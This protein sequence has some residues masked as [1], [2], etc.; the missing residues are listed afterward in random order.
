MAESRLEFKIIHD[1]ENKNVH[2]DQMSLEVAKAFVV[3]IQSVTSI[4]ELTP[5]NKELKI[6]VKKGSAMICLEGTEVNVVEKKF[7]QI[8][9]NKS[10][11]A[12]LVRQWRNIQELFSNNGLGYEASFYHKNAKVEI[13]DYLKSPKRLRTKRRS[14]PPISTNIEFVIGKLIAVGG[15]RPNIH[16]EINKNEKA[17]IIKC[18]EFKANK[19]KAFLYKTIWI[20]VWVTNKGVDK[21]F[22]MC[23]SYWET[24]NNMF[25]EFK[26]FISSMQRAENEIESLKK[27][28]YKC[29]EILKEGDFGKYRKFLRLF[30]TETSDLNAL[31]TILIVSRPFKDHER[32][33][34]LIEELDQ[35]F[36]KKLGKA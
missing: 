5:K 36:Q 32:L 4:V 10:S 16:V 1:T 8:I 18:T 28:H 19:A 33:Q 24:Q 30:N 13:L 12:E 25:N 3:L 22:T 23:D 7:R 14:S 21:E 20:S 17:T 6:S 31:K 15:K 9:E 11:D 29:Q 26:N 2:L 35:L 34:I 27:I